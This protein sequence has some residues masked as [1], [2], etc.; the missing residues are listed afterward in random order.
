MMTCCIGRSRRL[1]SLALFII[2]GIGLM[3]QAVTAGAWTRGKGHYY[4]KLSTSYLFANQNFDE[5]GARAAFT[6]PRF[7]GPD[8]SASNGRFID[9]ST[10]LYAEYGLSNSLDAIVSL[11][12]K[13]LSAAWDTGTPVGH[14]SEVENGREK[15][16]NLG[17]ADIGVGVKYG[18]TT[19]PLLFSLSLP[20]SCCRHIPQRQT[21]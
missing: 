10:Y 3:P 18:L 4:F 16:D 8:A 7:F 17:I 14:D 2:V 15:F 21:S 6:D 11:P 12:V 19:R 20:I 5:T 9:I 13:V 1:C